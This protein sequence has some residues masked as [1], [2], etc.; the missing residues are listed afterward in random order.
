[1]KI[2][3]VTNADGIS[4]T[5]LM[6]ALKAARFNNLS[7][8]DMDAMRD[9]RVWLSALAQDMAAQMTVPNSP[10]KPVEEPISVEA[11]APAGFKVKA[12]G[13][14]GSGSISKK[15]KKKG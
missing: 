4:C 14:I 13:P 7:T 8:E 10:P 11:P 12:M 5:V 2:S 9:A 6:K 1:M 3:N 15:S